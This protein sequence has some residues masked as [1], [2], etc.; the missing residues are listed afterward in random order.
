MYQKCFPTFIGFDFPTFYARTHAPVYETKHA[1]CTQC[2]HFQGRVHN[3]QRCAPGLRT[4]FFF[5]AIYHK[6]VHIRRV[7]GEVPGCIVSQGVHQTGA[8]SKSLISDTDGHTHACMHS[9]TLT[10]TLFIGWGPRNRG[11]DPQDT[12]V[13]GQGD[14][15]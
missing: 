8:H 3:F 1:P 14:S 13:V 9:C 6:Y 10:H 2:A 15:G 12:H 11:P 4:L 5:L 7:H